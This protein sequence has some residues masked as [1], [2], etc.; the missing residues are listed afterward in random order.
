MKK[1]LKGNLKRWIAFLLAVVLIATTCVYSSDAFLRAEGDETQAENQAEPASEEVEVIPTEV[2]EPE[3]DPEPEAEESNEEET[4]EEPVEEDVVEIPAEAPEEPD[5]NP[6]ETTTPEVLPESPETTPEQPADPSVSPAIDP[7][8]SPSVSPSAVPSASPEKEEGEV[9]SYTICYY[10][11]GVEDED[12]RVEK[13]DGVLGE[14]ILASVKVEGEVTV[15]GKDYKLD[16]IENKN[17]EITEDGDNTVKIYYESVDGKEIIEDVKEYSFEIVEPSKGATVSITSVDG[18]EGKKENTY[19]E[20]TKVTFEVEVDEGY[21]TPLVRDQKN[22]EVESVSADEEN[23]K[24]TYTVTITE[25]TVVTVSCAMA[26]GAMHAPKKARDGDPTTYKI[27]YMYAPEGTIDSGK[28]I[29]SVTINGYVGEAVS[30]DAVSREYTSVTDGEYV[31]T[32]KGGSF[33]IGDEAEP[34]WVDGQSIGIKLGSDPVKNIIYVIFASREPVSKV[35][36]IHFETNGGTPVN[37]MKGEAGISILNRGM[38]ETIKEG[39]VLEGWYSNESLTGNKITELPEVYPNEDI[40]YYAKWKE[41]EKPK[42]KLVYDA[43]GGEGSAPSA[44]TVESGME[45]TVADKGNLHKTGYEFDGWNTQADG[46]GNAYSVGASFTLDKDVT[47]YA[48]WKPNKNVSYTVH[49][50]L[51]GTEDK[52]AED[53][54]ETG[55][56]FDVSYTETA[57]DVAGYT[58]VGDKTQTFT[59]DEEGKEITFYYTADEAKIV[60]VTNGGSGVDD[61]DGATGEKISDRAMPE[62][63]RTGYEFGGWYADAGLTG[64]K[65]EELPESYPA[66]TTTYYASWTA[67]SDARYTVHYYLQDTEEKVAEDKTET[68]KTFGLEYTETAKEVTGY[69]LAGDGTQTFRLDGMNKEVTFYYTADEAKIVFV[70]NGGSGVGDMDG[71]TGEKISDRAMPTTARTGYTFGGWYANAG[72][73]GDKVGELPESYPAGTTTYYAAWAANTDVSYIVHYYVDGTTRSIAADKTETG[74]TFDVSYTETAVDV[75]GYTLVGDKTQ[76]FTLD[77]E[78]KEITFYYTADEAKIVF[79]TNGGSGVDDMDGATGEKISDRAMPET[80][81]TGYEFGGWYA[82]AGLTGDKVE[83]LPESYPAGTTTYYASWAANINTQYTVQYHY[84]N[85]LDG[86]YSDEEPEKKTATTD[87]SVSLTGKELLPTLTLESG[88]YIFD[89]SDSRNIL[90]GNVAGDG[91]LKLHVYFPIEYTINGRID[92][93]TVTESNQNVRYA[94]ASSAMSFTAER[95]YVIKS[96][97]VNGEEQTVTPNQ[98]TYTYPAQSDIK[99]DIEVQVTTEEMKAELTLTKTRTNE[100]A[101]KTGYVLGEAIEYKIVAKNTGNLTLNNVIVKDALVNGTWTIQGNLE[102]N[103]EREFTASYTVREDDIKAKEVVNTVTAEVPGL[104]PDYPKP[105]II[106]GEDKAPVDVPTPSLYVEK[107]ASGNDVP[108]KKY[109]EGEVVT[110]TIKVINNGNVTISNIVVEDPLTGMVWDVG[111]LVPSDNAIPLIRKPSKEKD[112]KYTIKPDDILAGKVVNTVTVSGVDPDGNPVDTTDTETI[113]TNDVRTD[114]SVAKEITSSSTHADGT[115]HV[116]D[117]IEYKIT[118][119]SDANVV[120]ENVRIADQLSNATDVVVFTGFDANKVTIGTDNV[121][122]IT[123]LV[124]GETVTLNCEYTVTRQDALLNAGL[125]DAGIRNSASVTAD[126]V[127]PTN[128]DDPNPKPV[129]EKETD[130]VGPAAVERVYT[131][132]VNYVYEAGGIAATSV[133]GQYLAGEIYRVDSPVIDGYTRADFVAGQMPN[134]DLVLTVVYAAVATPPAPGGDPAPDPVDPDTPPVPPVTPVDE[135]PDPVVPPVVPEGPAVP[136]APVVPGTPETVLITA[137]AAPALVAV[138]DAPVPLQGALIE[139]DDDGNVT[140][141][142]ITEEEIPLANKEIDDHKCCI[143]S[144]LLM[145]AT[146]IIYS[147]FTHSM[148]KRQKKLAELKD[149]LAEET[150]KRQLGITDKTSNRR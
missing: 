36:S 7:S 96:I 127:Q 40:T 130:P 147:W 118:I 86:S 146:L 68:G 110:Y 64:D 109:E 35:V 80:V 81:R 121:A 90:E 124:P 34:D 73:T 89:E 57:V 136:E 142:P 120:L 91:S 140:V 45:V 69:T 61:M 104:G 98:M 54:T 11:D 39:F 52:V 17:G 66:G 10:Y 58:L 8:A 101:N 123:E 38:P 95:N 26:F 135:V 100:P 133:I 51:Q 131:L 46:N 67:R 111:T 19:K 3:Q 77:E 92:H 137:P 85:P 144:F 99:E 116:G 84:Q 138:G 114:Y 41:K 94:A 78:G 29:G 141:T 134:N 103:E 43:N 115:Y 112:T 5:V 143:M 83:E 117:T 70:T 75:A 74:K 105:D 79:V 6:E 56:T 44:V 63:V 25:N 22:S 113:R 18:E 30:G 128:P 9:Y 27:I 108:G 65:V 42:V 59:L 48:Q 2:N 49:Y 15:D 102:P 88:R 62:T 53:K 93:G 87:T 76:T 97:M 71:V 13:E 129:P 122:T 148:K 24:Y 37:S 28:E 21:M 145:L 55:K 60:F 125:V 119:T 12:A 32:T 139:T 31:Y 16:K 20:N 1:I 4:E 72:L 149:Q 150:L 132:T 126:P 14:K 47:L 106:P 107:V 33:I 23:R 50:Y 82:D